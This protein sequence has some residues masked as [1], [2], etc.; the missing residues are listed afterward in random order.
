MCCRLRSFKGDP[1]WL[2]DNEDDES[3]TTDICWSSCLYYVNTMKWGVNLLAGRGLQ[4]TDTAD[5][6]PSCANCSPPASFPRE[7]RCR[8]QCR[9]CCP[10]NRVPTTFQPLT[11]VSALSAALRVHRSN[12]FTYQILHVHTGNAPTRHVYKINTTDIRTISTPATFKNQLKTY[13]LS[14][15][16]DIQ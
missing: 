5:T 7:A 8:T 6:Q 10:L 12:T 9:A 4:Q 13:L 11:Q 16:Y 15:S 1:C 2:C 3:V 14:F